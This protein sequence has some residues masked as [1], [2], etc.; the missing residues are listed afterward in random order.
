MQKR[1]SQSDDEGTSRPR[2]ADRS[3]RARIPIG[4]YRRRLSIGE[5]S[6]LSAR[7]RPAVPV[8]QSKLFRRV[9]RLVAPARGVDRID[10]D[11][12]EADRREDD[13]R[14][15]SAG[16]GAVYKR[17]GRRCRKFDRTRTTVLGTVSGA[18]LPA[19]ICHVDLAY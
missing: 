17:R 19:G 16:S 4:R 18:A 10:R 13:G 7:P 11:L 9:V 12:R 15:R 5:V 14:R 6:D 2:E 1:S 8:R 3:R